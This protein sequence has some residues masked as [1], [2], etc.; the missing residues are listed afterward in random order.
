[1]RVNDR[2]QVKGTAALTHWA[3]QN[4]LVKLGDYEK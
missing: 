1:M 3:I 4:K 2:L